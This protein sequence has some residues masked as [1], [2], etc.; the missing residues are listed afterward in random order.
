MRDR[1]CIDPGH[2]GRAPS[3]NSSPGGVRGPGGSLEKDFTLQLARRVAARL[4]SRAVLTRTRDENVSLARR[5]AIAREQ[6]ARGLISLHF[7][8]GPPGSRGAETWVHSSAGEGAF[9]LAQAVQGSLD[10]YGGGGGSV[11]S[12]PLALLSPENVGDLPACL[13]EVAYLS[14]AQ[15]EHRLRDPRAVDALAAAIARGANA[16]LGAP[17]RWGGDSDAAA[18]ADG[19]PAPA[20]DYVYPDADSVPANEYPGAWKFVNAAAGTFTPATQSRQVARIVM[21]TIDCNGSMD[22]AIA[23]YQDPNGARSVHFIVGQDAKVV[24]M[25]HLD[26]V[27]WHATDAIDL[28]SIAIAHVVRSASGDTAALPVSDDEYLASAALVHWLC[29]R[30][31]LAVDRDH[32]QSA[33]EIDPG[34]LFD[35]DRFMTAATQGSLA[36]ASPPT[37]GRRA[38]IPRVEAESILGATISSLPPVPTGAPWTDLISLRPDA[39]VQRA[40]LA[41]DPVPLPLIGT[42]IPTWGV[43]RIEDAYGPINLDEYKVMI[44]TMPLL[45][46][47]STPMTDT[48]LALYFRWHINDFVDT[49]IARFTPYGVGDAAMWISTSPVG[50]AIHIAM[51]DDGTV[52]CSQSTPLDFVFSTT[53]SYRDG[54]HP[55]SGNRQFGVRSNPDGG[56]IL[57]T[58][59]ADRATTWYHWSAGDA[60]FSGGDDLWRS[61]Q[62]H[63]RDWINAHGG[64]ASIGSRFSERFEWDPI[65]TAY[66]HPTVGWV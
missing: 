47:T 16:F 55:V 52:V 15:T 51:T 10:R 20:A 35:W 12:G 53:Q 14:D 32:V 57:Y 56:W 39:T 31:Q 36:P 18:A 49:S 25:L 34:S 66:S 1:I 42:P 64:S 8:S 63:A 60:V 23:S 45:P 9:E 28:D 33:S 46:G 44:S 38:R 6:G 19:V 58:R 43:H 54:A 22:D 41:R 40:L 26:D 17:R 30:Y 2:G 24:Q 13:V 21:H 7:N 27:A 4:G 62:V 29:D 11:R 3:G 61:F 37:Y 65:R 5:A 48:Q 50:A 59:G